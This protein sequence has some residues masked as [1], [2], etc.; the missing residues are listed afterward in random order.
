MGS[1]RLLVVEVWRRRLS[2]GDIL[3]GGGVVK[4]MLT[5]RSSFPIDKDRSTSSRE[6]VDGYHDW[7]IR[8]LGGF[9]GWRR[10]LVMGWD[11]GYC[12]LYRV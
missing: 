11:V 4:E 9:F 8:F 12:I 10:F 7:W 3:G 2:D 6:S 5:A 1:I